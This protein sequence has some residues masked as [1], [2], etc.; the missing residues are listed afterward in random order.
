MN[1]KHQVLRDFANSGSMFFKIDDGEEKIV[2]FISFE[3]AP[4]NFDGG[5]STLIRYHLEFNGEKKMWDRPS[6]KLAEQMAEIPF[7]A[8][9]KI[10]RKGQK[11]QTVYFIEEIK[12]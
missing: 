9:I 4:N 1:S 10:K 3:K 6:R 7:G 11:N 12:E 8:L 2:R 5:K